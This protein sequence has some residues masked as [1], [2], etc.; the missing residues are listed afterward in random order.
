MSNNSREPLNDFRV[1][2][3]AGKI[4]LYIQALVNVPLYHFGELGNILY[5]IGKN[6]MEGVVL[7]TKFTMA[8]NE[9]KVAAVWGCR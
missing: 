2:K 9:F 8:E 5:T 3:L 6:M 1:P 7:Y 4:R